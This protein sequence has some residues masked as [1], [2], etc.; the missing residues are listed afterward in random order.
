MGLL[1]PT[2]Y[3]KRLFDITPEILE[4][5]GAS[6]VLLDIDNT[7]ASYI[8]HE[9]LEG[10]EAWVKEM[11]AEGFRL[12]IVSNNYAERVEPFAGKFP[13]PFISRAYKPLPAG[14][15]KAAKE[16]GLR[17]KDCVIIGDQIYTDI[18]GANLCGMK[19][20][21]LEPIEIETSLSFRIRRKLERGI[22]AKLAKK[23]ENKNESC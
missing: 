11:S 20:I 23:K 6:A 13:L 17:R 21:L 7:L 10:A 14:Y 3:A 2:L 5:L 4:K 22:R 9:P 1:T 8:S 18:I 16:L 19:S 12:I 15:I